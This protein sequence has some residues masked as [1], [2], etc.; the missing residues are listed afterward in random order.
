MP[1]KLPAAVNT[2]M[3]MVTAIS[4]MVNMEVLPEWLVVSGKSYHDN[5]LETLTQVKVLKL[6]N[7]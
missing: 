7:R 1:K 4:L 5:H 2:Q 3:V 6:P